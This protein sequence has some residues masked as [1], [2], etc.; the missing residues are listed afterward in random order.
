MNTQNEN[1]KPGVSHS[2]R[3]WPGI[4]IVI[5]QLIIGFILPQIWPETMM[6]GVL[7]SMILGLAVLLWWAFFSRAPKFERWI[8][9]LLIIV[10]M[11]LTFYF[12][13]KSI[14]T[15][16]MGL[17][18]LIFSIPSMSLVFVAWAIATSRLSSNPRMAIMIA[19]IFLGS[20]IWLL[21]KSTGL[22]GDGRAKFT[23]RWTV[24]P[25]E[26]LLA[27]TNNKLQAHLADSTAI[28][29][30]IVWS[31]FR[32]TNRDGII[33][34]VKIATDWKSTPPAEIWRK[35]IGPGCSSFAVQGNLVYTQEQRGEDESVSCY[36]L[37]TGEPIWQH[38]DKARFWDS[39]AGAGPRG[40]PILNNNRVYTLGATGILN[41]L[42]AFTGK[43]IW[44]NNVASETKTATPIWG[45]SGSPLVTDSMVIIALAGSIAS[46]EL[47]TGKQIW[48]NQAGGDCYS[49]P[50]LANINGA[51]Q[52]L[53][54]NESGVQ[55]YSPNDGKMLWEYASKGNP[56]LQPTFAPN[57]N[58]LL[59]FNAFENLSCINVTNQVNGWKIKEIWTSTGLKPNHNDIVVHKGFAYGMDMAGLECIDIEKGERKWK[60]NRYGGQLLLLADQDILLILSEKGELVL[61]KADPDKFSELGRFPAIEGKTWNHPVLAGNVLLVRNMQEM[62][63]FRL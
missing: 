2:L 37:K 57:G 46:F 34:G 63:A 20:G 10:G 53:L 49:S 16:N 14:S 42:D 45:F 32:G 41:A 38:R 59:S 39:H 21:F 35:P 12:L 33:H 56:I 18:F 52:I 48:F 6:F 27:N 19:S 50:H 30:E 55:S 8:A 22:D 47:S 5:V 60:G 24:D 31:G 40:T 28:N 15:G 11:V 58:V 51:N 1:K 29:S 3:L 36:D 26:V 44:S 43:L 61:V 62:A 17:M 7:G 25:E 9:P 23:W 54:L 13:D 4:S